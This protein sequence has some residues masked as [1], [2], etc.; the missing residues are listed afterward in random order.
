MKR[1]DMTSVYIVCSMDGAGAVAV[2]SI[3]F[4]LDIFGD[5]RGMDD[6]FATV[7]MQSVFR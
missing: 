2:H 6:S 7:P 4:L 3:V 1:R 5:M